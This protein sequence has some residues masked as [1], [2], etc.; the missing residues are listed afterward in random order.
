ML[1]NPQQEI[2]CEALGAFLLRD[3]FSLTKS[4]RFYKFLNEEFSLMPVKT[5]GKGDQEKTE[6]RIIQ[7]TDLKAWPY[8]RLGLLI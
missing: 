5:I 1:P 4:H 8:Y 3:G 6:S 7:I 2:S